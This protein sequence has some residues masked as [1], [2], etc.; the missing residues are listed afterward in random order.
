MDV[1]LRTLSLLDA[2]VIA[3]AFRA[4]GG[5]GKTEEDYTAY[6]ARQQSDELVVLV[7]WLGCVS[8]VCGKR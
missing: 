4:L 2:P 6:F 3:A 1:E 7:A 8:E 5:P